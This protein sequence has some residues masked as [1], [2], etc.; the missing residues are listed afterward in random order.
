MPAGTLLSAFAYEVAPRQV[1]PFSGGAVGA[2]PELQAALDQVFDKSKIDS[3]PAVTFEVDTTSNTRSHPIRDVAVQLAFVTSSDQ[4]AVAGLAQR[5]GASMDNRSKP[6]L[7]MVSVHEAPS[8]KS[9]RVLLWSFPQQQVF[10]LYVTSGTASLELLEAFNRESNLRKVAF[11]EGSNTASGLLTARVLDFQASAAERVVADLWIVKFLQARL[12]MSDAEGTQLLARALR[13]AHSK[14][15]HDQ[16]AQDQIMAAITGLRV[17]KTARWSLDSVA[18]AYLDGPAAAA[19]HGSA[20]PEERAAVFAIDPRR[21]DQL[22]QY[23]RFT[24]DNGVVVSAPFAELEDN[25]CVRIEDVDGRRRLQLEGT[26]ADEQ[27]R[28]RV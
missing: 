20:R 19:F 24:L 8:A 26:I 10:N 16:R 3:A 2:T 9:R 12:Q 5:L 28:T 15:R 23:K 27:V 1:G 21:L 7:L 17:T 14:T 4:L 22:L 11:L 18:S 25:S 13:A 6:T